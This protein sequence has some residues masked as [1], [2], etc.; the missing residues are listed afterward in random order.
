MPPKLRKKG[1]QSS[2]RP[3]TRGTPGQRKNISDVLADSGDELEHL[4]VDAED[5]YFLIFLLL[6]FIDSYMFSF[7]R[8]Y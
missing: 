3:P 6:F 5:R 8:Q 2:G 7:S 4:T 1:L